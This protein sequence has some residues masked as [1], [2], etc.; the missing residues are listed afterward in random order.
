MTLP[1]NV[2]SI[3]P[4]LQVEDDRIATLAVADIKRQ[5]PSLR[6]SSN[7]EDVPDGVITL[8][9][10]DLRKLLRIALA[11]VEVDKKW[12][13]TQVPAL[14]KAI[15]D[16]AFGSP[17]E[18][19]H[20]HGYLEGRLPKKPTVDEEYYLQTYPDVAQAVRSGKLKSAYEHY[21]GCGYAEGRNP[22]PPLEK[23][24]EQQVIQ[25]QQL[26]PT[27]EAAPDRRANLANSS[28]SAGLKGSAQRHRGGDGPGLGRR[29]DQS[30]L[31]AHG[32]RPRSTDVVMG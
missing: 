15:E 17:S 18:H 1:P 5:L 32:S 3:L 8:S 21:T 12:Y 22:T 6:I 19:Y 28:A 2:K 10:E 31:T 20:V 30:S 11:G 25:K 13:L 27:A 4:S 14:G 16:G 26:T 7:R 24:K 29:H 9:I 23:G